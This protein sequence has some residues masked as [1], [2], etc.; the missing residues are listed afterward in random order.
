MAPNVP[1]FEK[2]CPLNHTKATFC[3]G[4]SKNG[5][6]EK[7]FAQKLAQNFSGN[8]GKIRAKILHAPKNVPAPTPIG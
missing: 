8:F 2:N 4:R 1:S 7:I 3:G 5:L 6:H